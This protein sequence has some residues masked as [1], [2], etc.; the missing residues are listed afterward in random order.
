MSWLPR[1]TIVVPVDFSP[2]SAAA[3]ATGRD[4]V[5]SPGDLHVVHVLIPL[6][7]LS[8]EQVWGPLENDPSWDAL[9]KRHLAEFVQ[10]QGISGVKQEVLIGD[11]GFEV[12]DYARKQSADLIVIPSHGYHGVKRA[13]LGSVAERVIR[14]ADCPVL[15]LRRPDAS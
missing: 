12:A 7:H 13:L 5:A 1:K 15:V 8:P 14:H 10:K 6:A 9:A 3:I 2:G 4:L 11:P